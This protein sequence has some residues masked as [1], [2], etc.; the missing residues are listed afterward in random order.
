MLTMLEVNG[1]GGLLSLP[2]SDISSG[3]I[4]QQVDGLD[5]VKATLSSTA[6]AGLDGE[7]YQSSRRETRN[8]KITL[9]LDPDPLVDTVRTLRKRLYSYFLPKSQI[10]L[11]FYM[12]DG[13]T[14]S[15]AGVVESFETT[16]FSQTP[17]VDISIICYDPDFYDP[18]PQ[19]LNG[20]S[21]ESSA[22]TNLTYDGEVETGFV[23][24]LNV[25]R[26]IG[27]VTIYN[28]TPNEGIRS[29][30]FTGS[31]VAGDV[32]TISTVTGNKGATLTHLG[33][34]SSVLY[35]VSPQSSWVD[36]KPGL[37]QIRIYVTGAA[38]IPYSMQYTTKY[39][40]L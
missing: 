15:I 9:G 8:I 26:T 36:L 17:S 3:F 38:G 18:T 14:V 1:Q 22:V 27:E 31:L 30:D 24:T 13:L 35:G 33:A 20:N 19:T 5:P 40:G 10:T 11:T 6:F 21:T 34:S 23:F 16:I 29:L 39:G 7:Q 32:L 25:N 12:D 2:L 28:T 37:N 4:V